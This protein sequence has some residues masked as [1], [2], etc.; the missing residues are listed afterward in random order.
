MIGSKLTKTANGR[1]EPVRSSEKKEGTSFLKDLNINK[2]NE[3]T[4]K[5]DKSFRFQCPLLS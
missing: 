5:S 1:L 3:F 2:I 4:K